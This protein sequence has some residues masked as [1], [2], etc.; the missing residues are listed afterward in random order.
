MIE[1]LK[2]ELL[3]KYICTPGNFRWRKDFTLI[4][5][6]LRIFRYTQRW[7]LYL[8]LIVLIL[9]SITFFFYLISFIYIDELFHHDN[10]I[11]LFD[12]LTKLIE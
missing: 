10:A 11:A 4:L 6:T 12:L 3:K 2:F 9:L 5:E 1:L 7:E 8:H